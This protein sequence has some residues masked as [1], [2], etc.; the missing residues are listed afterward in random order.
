MKDRAAIMARKYKNDAVY[1]V[2]GNP[3]F[4][5]AVATIIQGQGVDPKQIKFEK[6]TGY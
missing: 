1:Y 6:F 3:G 4:V 2:A 5:T